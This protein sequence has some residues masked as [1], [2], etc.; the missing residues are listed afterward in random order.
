MVKQ[1]KLEENW[2]EAG[3]DDLVEAEKLEEITNITGTLL[4]KKPPAGNRES[5]IYVIQTGSGPRE[6]WG[7]TVLDRKMEKI[8][9][10]SMVK[11]EYLGLKDSE[12]RKGKQ[13]HDVRVHY[14]DALREA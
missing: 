13:Y 4:N 3:L 14:R 9:V 8:R 12:K 1:K 6:I 11:L 7:F 5:W 10:G 2:K